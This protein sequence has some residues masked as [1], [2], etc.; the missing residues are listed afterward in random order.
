MQYLMVLLLSL[1]VFVL[2]VSAVLGISYALGALLH[3]RSASYAD[4][5]NTDPCAQCYAD[6]SWYEDLPLWKRNLVTA[7]WLANR[8][9]C[10]SRGCG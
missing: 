7:W 9:R 4:P 10:A 1:G 6:R 2:M 5:L 8:Y 3:S